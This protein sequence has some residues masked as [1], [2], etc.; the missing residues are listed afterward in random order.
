[1]SDRRSAMMRLAS[2]LSCSLALS[3]AARFLPDSL[4]F[5]LLF[6]WSLSYSMHGWISAG[7]G[8]QANRQTDRKIDKQHSKTR[9]KHW[10]KRAGIIA[11][12]VVFS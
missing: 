7:T 12:S 10:H 11:H 1:M 9:T 6:P 8:N 4:R 2:L 3:V 5:L